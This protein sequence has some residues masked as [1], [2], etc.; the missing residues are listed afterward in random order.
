M[1]LVSICREALARLSGRGDIAL[2]IPRGL[3]PVMAAGGLEPGGVDRRGVRSASD[4]SAI[5]DSAARVRGGLGGNV[6]DMRVF[7]SKET[8]CAAPDPD[9]GAAVYEDDL[10]PFWPYLVFGQWT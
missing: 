2:Q 7:G 1:M 5:A 8:G 3:P 9:V 4:A 6:L 10:A